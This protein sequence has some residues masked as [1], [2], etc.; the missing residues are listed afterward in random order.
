MQSAWLFFAFK[1]CFANLVIVTNYT[2]IFEQ[3]LDFMAKISIIMF[4]NVYN[5]MNNYLWL[6]KEIYN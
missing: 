4:S 6:F 2:V 1:K 3:A 5:C